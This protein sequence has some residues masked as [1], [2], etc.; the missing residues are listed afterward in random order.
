[1]ALSELSSDYLAPGPRLNRLVATLICGHTDG[2][3]EG[4]YPAYSTA[5]DLAFEA[6]DVF[7]SGNEKTQITIEYPEPEVLVKRFSERMTSGWIPV[8]HVAGE[9]LGHALCLAILISAGH[10]GEIMRQTSSP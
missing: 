3:P 7:L 9:N 4:S 5:V 8:A 1:M 6:V 2:L 10:R